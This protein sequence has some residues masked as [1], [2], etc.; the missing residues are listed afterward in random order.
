M[1]N[2]ARLRKTTENNKTARGGRLPTIISPFTISARPWRARGGTMSFADVVWRTIRG[3]GGDAVFT[4]FGAV[5]A[6]IQEG[7]GC[8]SNMM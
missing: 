6:A 7:V 8:V 4:R 1:A 3:P 5:R 2:D